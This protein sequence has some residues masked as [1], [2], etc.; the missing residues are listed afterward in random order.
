M[1]EAVPADANDLAARVAVID[2]H[3]SALEAALVAQDASVIEAAS[4]RLHACL[5]DA[6]SAFQQVPQQGQDA[7]PPPLRQRL[8][9]L[10]ARVSSQQGLAARALASVDRTLQVL[11]PSHGQAADTYA[12][13]GQKAASAYRA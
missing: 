7:L 9:Q 3:L 5:G 6:L 13:L 2:E 1:T 8:L 11:L 12:S 4:A 10:Q